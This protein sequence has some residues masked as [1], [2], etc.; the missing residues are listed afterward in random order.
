MRTTHLENESEMF[1]TILLRSAQRLLAVA[2]VVTVAGGMGGIALVACFA[3][4]VVA[5]F[6]SSSGS[7]VTP[8]AEFGPVPLDTELGTL[9][10]PE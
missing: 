4:D 9:G 2:L 3:S 10:S 1:T 7:I 8:Q 5:S 6:A